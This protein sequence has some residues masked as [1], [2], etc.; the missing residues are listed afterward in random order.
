MKGGQHAELVQKL[1]ESADPREKER[2]ETVLRAAEGR[3]SLEDLAELA[4]RARS[5]IQLWMQK[6]SH[7]GVAGLLA[8][9]TPPGSSSPIGTSKIN[10]ELRAGLKRGRWHTAAEVAVWLKETH[11]IERS[12]T[13]IYYWFSQKGLRDGVLRHSGKKRST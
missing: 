5:T 10:A 3:H 4:G 13:S 6:F 2:I 9:D 8:R 1:R 11:G 7:G 12:R